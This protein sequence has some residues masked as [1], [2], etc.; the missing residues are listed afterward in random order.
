MNDKIKSFFL[1]SFL[2]FLVLSKADAAS[3]LA[4]PTDTAG[5]SKSDLWAYLSLNITTQKTIPTRVIRVAVVD[6]GFRLSH[7]A[8]RNYIYTNEKEVPGNFQDDDQNGYMD[9]IQGWD[10]SDADND[11][12]V[13]VG[14]EDMYY[15][16]TYITGIITAV[17]ERFYGQ[18]ASKYLKIVPVKVLSDKAKNTYL[19]D[20]YKG[21]KY[22]SEMGVDI[23]CCAWSGGSA[24]D[25][26]KEI[27]RNAI[28][29]GI[30]I[31]GST[32]NFYS[33]KVETPSSLPGVISVAA[34][35]S[36]LRKE[37][38]SNYGMRVDV[39]APGKKVYGAYPLADNSYTYFD[40]TSPAAAI[41]TGCL[42]GLK[43][44]SPLLTS[45]ELL[46]AIKNTCIPL[47]S[48]NIKQVG[49]L[50]AGFPDMSKAIEYLKNPNYKYQSF[51]PIRPEG[52]SF[53]RTKV[54]PLSWNIKPYGAY[55]GI[56]F[57]S[58][59]PGYN[60]SVK[61]Y[62]SDSVCYSGKIS[63]L[64][65]GIFIGGSVFKVE[66]QQN[67]K[68][69]KDMAFSYYME[70]IDS[71]T[72]YCKGT[73][74]ITQESGTLT[75][76]SGNENYANNSDC[77]WQ[78]IVPK[79]K[80]IRIEFDSMDTQANV[81]YVSIFDGTA[82]IP[83]NLLAKFSGTNIPPVITTLSNEVLIW[84]V[85]DGTTTGKGWK[86]KYEAVGQQ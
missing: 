73:Q 76:N 42:A 82:T 17:F 56:H 13:P 86:L 44:I 83:D 39:S 51:N 30:I 34:V 54:S 36:A 64:Y 8:I 5:K 16:G 59:L 57:Y 40:G 19:A 47:D 49:K 78:L 32:G 24:S 1:L 53:Y 25:E 14:K 31:V 10:V 37:K 79:G 27:V 45:Q 77:K 80:R 9:D 22:A 50:G 72:L 81:D 29:K 52:L 70:T 58:A 71:T 62:N 48:N 4:L 67:S 69:S 11:V 38:T 3:V 6:D 20:G 28:A 60:G 26:E 46:S 61:I 35:D 23:I 68:L 21:I 2:L 63:E 7:K 33:E 55:K 85:T 43:S 15:H 74:F 84:F 18:E 65:K 41:I 12:S 66:L 75:D